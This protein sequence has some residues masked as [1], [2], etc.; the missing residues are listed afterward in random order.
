MVIIKEYFLFESCESND[1]RCF[2]WDPLTLSLSQMTQNVCKYYLWKKVFL[3]H[4]VDHCAS[5]T[6]TCD[7]DTDY[8]YMPRFH[9][10]TLEKTRFHRFVTIFEQS[11]VVLKTSAAQ[12]F[13]RLYLS[14]TNFQPKTIHSTKN[15]KPS[16]NQ[17]HI[18]V[19]SK[20]LANLMNL[21]RYLSLTD[22]KTNL[23]DHPGSAP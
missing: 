9:N 2:D 5:G 14:L 18:L 21:D 17:Q 23:A 8:V 22:Q 4:D 12:E 15:Q 1:S 10:F 19:S 11:H 20:W 13:F 3:D 16:S 6:A 7:T